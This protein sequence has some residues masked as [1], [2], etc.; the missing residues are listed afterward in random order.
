[1]YETNYCDK[2]ILYARV[3]HDSKDTF[4]EGLWLMESQDSDH[5]GLWLMGN[6]RVPKDT[7]P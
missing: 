1:M 7:F 6:A 2:I 3:S 4:H 5:E